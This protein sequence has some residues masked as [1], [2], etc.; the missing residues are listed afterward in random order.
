M[1]N[2]SP[3]GSSRPA[4]GG[5]FAWPPTSDELDAIQ[6]IPL[7][8]TSNG[9]MPSKP[10]QLAP[11]S[12]SPLLLPTPVAPAAIRRRHWSHL[13]LRLPRRDDFVLA[14]VT[15]TSVLAIATAAF[16]Q[17]SGTP[18]PPAE[19]PDPPV[20]LEASALPGN[21][22]LTAMSLPVMSLPAVTPIA[23]APLVAAPA[24]ALARTATPTSNSTP[25]QRNVARVTTWSGKAAHAR[26]RHQASRV[27]ARH[28]VANGRQI[29]RISAD[30]AGP[31][32]ISPEYRRNGKLVLLVEVRKNGKVGDVDVLSSN[33]DR[34][35]RSHRD[36]QRAAIST[37]KRWRYTP[38]IRDGAPAES[39]IRVVVDINLDSARVA[40]TEANARRRA[41]AADR[42][43]DSV[44]AA[45]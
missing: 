22:L 42:A 8:D 10:A 25:R 31:R 18:R 36:L 12:R 16:M 23:S 9:P 34:D 26:A 17:L 15:M 24:A 7:D 30:D 44:L 3:P 39:Q 13:S 6:V 35:N 41:A 5:E 38:A 27:V 11:P 28:H 40:F 2:D 43:A 33:L 21:E 32:L 37:V 19:S 14:G 29:T 1:N 20:A 4:A 45:R